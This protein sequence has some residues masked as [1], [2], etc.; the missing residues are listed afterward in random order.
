MRI[1]AVNIPE[2]ATS[3]YGLAPISMHSLGPVVVVAGKNGSGKTRLLRCINEI[4][5]RRNAVIGGANKEVRLRN[6]DEAD[7][8]ITEPFVG[9]FS[10]MPFVPTRPDVDNPNDHNLSQMQTYYR[11]A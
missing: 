11:Q 3:K 6:K 1:T 5:N 9:K 10:M 4:T 8:I 2:A 7:W